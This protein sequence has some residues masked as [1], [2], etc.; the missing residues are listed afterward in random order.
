MYTQQTKKKK[1]TLLKRENCSEEI[2]PKYF[3]EFLKIKKV[4]AEQA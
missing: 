1:S 4:L 3:Q 2:V